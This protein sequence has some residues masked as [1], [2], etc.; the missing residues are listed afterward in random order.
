VTPLDLTLAVVAAS[1][2]AWGAF[3]AG[4]LSRSGAVAA[5]LVGSIVLS[6]GWPWGLFL[7]GWFIAAS[8]LSK[9]GH[10]AKAARTGDVVAK[11]D[12][13]DAGQVVA[14]GGVFTCAAAV[15]L[16][17]P[18]WSSVAAVAGAGALAAAGSDTAATEIGTL[19]GGTPWSLRTRTAA[20]PGSSGAISRV[21]TMGMLAAAGAFAALAAAVGLVAW[22]DAGRV[23]YAAVC[24]AL[25]DTVA[26]AWLQARRWCPRCERETE[27]VM[28]RCGT[29][30][31]AAGGLAWLGNDWVNLVCT[32]VGAAVGVMLAGRVGTA[33][34]LSGLP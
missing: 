19:W 11:G 21:G 33:A 22:G 34:P 17:V 30:T 28:H 32:L 3:R 14:N 8:A 18:E 26:G 29:P 12:A 5:A 27:Q 13:R 9:M 6:A 20:A 25:V 31:L 16:L 24:G 15:S 1:A 23:A 7:V 10:A 4:S 2:I